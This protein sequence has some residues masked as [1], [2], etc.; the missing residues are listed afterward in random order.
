MDYEI[1]GK[2]I[3]VKKIKSSNLVEKSKKILA[4]GRVLDINGEPIIG[5][6]VLEKGTTNGTITDFDGNFSLDVPLN[7]T[8]EISYVGYQN[9]QIIV[10]TEKPYT[11]T[12]KEDSETLD[13]IVVVGYGVQKKSDVTG[14]VGS[15]NSDHILSKGSTS[16][17]ESLQGQVAGVDISQSSSRA[18]EGFS[19]SIRG[20][21]SMAGGNPLYVIDGVVCD[22]MDFLNPA[23]IEKLIF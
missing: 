5:A 8:L 19:I 18:G 22:N 16:V 6:T 13:E 4:S 21:S 17:M 3:I 14:A 23:D 2:K 1:Q 20:K 10:Q 7:I 9:Q 11:I 15:V 12:L